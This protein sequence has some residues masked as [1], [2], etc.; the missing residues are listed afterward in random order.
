[1]VGHDWHSG[2]PATNI[3]F[4]DADEACLEGIDLLAF[5]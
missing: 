2:P 5:T 3:P 4:Y 1:M